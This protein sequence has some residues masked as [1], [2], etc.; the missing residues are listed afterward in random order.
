LASYHV[1]TKTYTVIGFLRFVGVANAA[2]W[3]GAAVFFTAVVGP[4][5]F[6]PDVFKLFGW[7]G[8]GETARY[9][10]GSVA[11]VLVERYFRLHLICGVIALTHLVLEWGL[12]RRPL[13]RGLLVLGMALLGLS[14]VASFW[15]QPKMRQ[16][17]WTMY[18]GGGKVTVVQAKRA[19]STFYMWHGIAQAGNLAALAGLTVYLWRLTLPAASP[20]FVTQ[21]K[22]H[23]E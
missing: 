13:R 19:R 1:S 15:L 8:T 20:R 4:G 11:L 17:H 10:A 16:L 3:F 7:P 2:V 21:T 12:I 22:F 9:W 14:L 5:L 6:S 18:G 23:L